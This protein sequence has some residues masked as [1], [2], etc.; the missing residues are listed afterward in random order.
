MPARGYTALFARMLD[1]PRITVRT[2]VDYFDV[3][4][5]IAPDR[6]RVHG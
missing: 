5:E 2:G 1:H 6:H 4:R 3:R